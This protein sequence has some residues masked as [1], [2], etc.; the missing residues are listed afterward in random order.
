MHT[1]KFFQV[2]LPQ[3]DDVFHVDTITFKV[4]I[5]FF[6]FRDADLK[7]QDA[8]S[9]RCLRFLDQESKGSKLRELTMRILFCLKAYRSRTSKPFSKCYTR[10][11]I[12]AFQQLECLTMR[13]MRGMTV[14]TRIVTGLGFCTFQR[15]GTFQRCVL[16]L[17]HN[18][19]VLPSVFSKIRKLTIESVS[20]YMPP[21]FP[22]RDKVALAKKY[23]VKKW[24]LEE[25]GK[26]VL[27]KDSLDV[28]GLTLQLGMSSSDIISLLQIRELY[29]ARSC[30]GC[31]HSCY[32]SYSPRLDV[33]KL[34]LERFAA[35]F[36]SME[37][38]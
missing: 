10:N 37:D 7:P 36:V 30:R 3:R 14:S 20:P 16:L 11:C 38:E 34:I 5:P 21:S 25:Y 29:F 6:A 4:E 1:T 2:N 15:N 31:S 23:N 35:H 24:L 32:A 8:S 26:L 22:M 17:A 12:N 18:R 9:P 28:G 33:D 13:P 27:Q 19:P